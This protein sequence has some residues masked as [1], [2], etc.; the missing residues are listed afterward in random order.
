MRWRNAGDAGVPVLH[1]EYGL[2]VKD[3]AR[4]QMILSEDGPRRLRLAQE[5]LKR[6][7]Q[8]GVLRRT[9]LVTNCKPMS[10]EM[11]THR[12][13]SKPFAKALVVLA[14][15]ARGADPNTW[16]VRLASIS[17]LWWDTVQDCR[18]H[19]WHSQA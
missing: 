10:P 18:D 3:A 14:D 1:A 13:W 9:M 6:I 16:A 12:A 15:I 17:I 2:T 5:D 4:L 19:G 7:A 11:S 8:E